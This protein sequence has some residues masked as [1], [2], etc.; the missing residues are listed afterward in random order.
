MEL[1]GFFAYVAG[2]SRHRSS[3][4]HDC[5]IPDTADRGTSLAFPI[6]IAQMNLFPPRLVLLFLLVVGASPLLADLPTNYRDIEAALVDFRFQEAGQSIARVIS[7][8]Y[9]AF[10]ASNLQAYRAMAGMNPREWERYR[11]DWDDQYAAIEDLPEN[12]SLREILLADLATKRALIEFMDHSYLQ[13]A[14]YARYA[15]RSLELSEARFGRMPEQYKLK[16]LFEVLLGSLPERFHWIAHP[17]GLRGNVRS[18]LRYLK[19]AAKDSRLLNTEGRLLLCLIEKNMLNQPEQALGALERTKAA[20]NRPAILID[21]FLASGYLNTKQTNKALTIL[22]QRQQY[23]TEEVFLLPF[24]D[25]QLGKAHYYRGEHQAA[26]VA[27]QRFVERYDGKL[28]RSDAIFR[29]GMAYAFQGQMP[30]ART[31]FAVIAGDEGEKFDEDGYATA[32]ARRFLAQGPDQV[33]LELFLARNLFDG[34]YYAEALATLDNTR[35]HFALRPVQLVEW[36]Y[37]KARVLHTQGKLTLAEQAYRR[38]LSYQPDEYTDYLH[39]YS[40]FF[41]GDIARQLGQRQAA[42]AWYEQALSYD[43]YFYQSGLE[44]RCKAARAQLESNQT[45]ASSNRR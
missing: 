45:Q 36:H 11:S 30:A 18:G 6:Q 15:K 40:A 26:Q 8:G 43:D 35:A 38:A 27:F 10:Y 31:Y 25:Y 17:L 28:F 39:A 29:I 33:T 44:N 37:R 14:R 16:G 41:L 4:R 9:R 21:F 5:H 7:P 42:E 23:D 19:L 3:L 20:L 32:M 34:G 1:R 2:N 13:A 12:D 24:W 22:Q